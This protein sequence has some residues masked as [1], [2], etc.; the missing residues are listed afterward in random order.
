[1]IGRVVEFS[2]MV[3]V[4]T[5]LYIGVTFALGVDQGSDA[6]KVG[7]ALVAVFSGPLI[8]IWMAVDR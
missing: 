8:R 1:M 4:L 2:A 6:C 7:G 5:L 3:V